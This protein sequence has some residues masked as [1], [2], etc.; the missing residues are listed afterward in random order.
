M[1]FNTVGAGWLS[2]WRNNRFE[3]I[4]ARAVV[5]QKASPLFEGL[6]ATALFPLL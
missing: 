6:S 1:P 4:P 2:T 5:G 3:R